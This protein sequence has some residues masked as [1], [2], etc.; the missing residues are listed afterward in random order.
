MLSPTLSPLL[1]LQEASAAAQGGLHELKGFVA[2]DQG[3]SNPNW[4][5]ATVAAMVYQHYSNQALTPCEWAT[6]CIGDPKIPHQ[7]C[8]DPGICDHTYSI[9]SALRGMLA[10][11]SGAPLGADAIKAEIDALPGR[12]IVCVQRAAAHVVVIYGIDEP[13]PG[14]AYV[15]SVD[16]A[17]GFHSKTE[18]QEFTT[19]TDAGWSATVLTKPGGP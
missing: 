18:I 8:L 11:V 7:C 5:W 9:L 1:D 6:I 2:L 14:Q 16:P 12:P 13:A 19:R 17:G 15:L 3:A 10:A 4:C